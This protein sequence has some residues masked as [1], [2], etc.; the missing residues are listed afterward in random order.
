MDINSCAP[1]VVHSGLAVGATRP[2]QSVS[3]TPP[4]GLCALC[5]PSA[6]GAQRR[7]R[8]PNGFRTWTVESKR[9]VGGASGDPEPDDD[10]RPR[11]RRPLSKNVRLHRVVVRLLLHVVACLHCLPVRRIFRIAK[12]SHKTERQL[13]EGRGGGREVV[14]EAAAVGLFCQTPLTIIRPQWCEAFAPAPPSRLEASSSCADRPEPPSCAGAAFNLRSRLDVAFVVLFEANRLRRAGS[15]LTADDAASEAL[16]FLH[17]H[18]LTLAV[19]KVAR[20]V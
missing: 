16:R 5:V 9:I 14:A 4:C 10:V 12:Y 2:V 13:S 8:L 17:A 11:A 6:P 1:C 19:T 20:R 15:L 3:S 18:Q 7:D